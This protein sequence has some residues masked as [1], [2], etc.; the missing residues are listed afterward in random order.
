MYWLLIG[1][2]LPLFILFGTGLYSFPESGLVSKTLFLL[3]LLLH[4]SCFL[5]FPPPVVNINMKTVYFCLTDLLSCKIPSSSKSQDD[6]S[7]CMESFYLEGTWALEVYWI[8][9][10]SAIPME[11]NN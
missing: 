3:C 7:E 8:G 10:L 5:E 1:L 6:R 9:C 2:G 11:S 4:S